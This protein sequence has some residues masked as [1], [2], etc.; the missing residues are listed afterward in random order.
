MTK[1]QLRKKE[2]EVESLRAGLRKKEQEL[3]LREQATDKQV[4]AI[5]KAEQQRRSELEQQGKELEHQR[6]LAS[7]YKVA[8]NETE[9]P[10]A[11]AAFT[12]DSGLASPDAVLRQTSL[13]SP[14]REAG[15]VHQ[16]TPIRGSGNGRPRSRAR[17]ATGDGAAGPGYSAALSQNLWPSTQGA[18]SIVADGI[19][20]TGEFGMLLS[21]DISD[22]PAMKSPDEDFIEN[23]FAS[24]RRLKPSAATPTAAS[25][26]VRSKTASPFGIASHRLQSSFQG[27]SLLRSCD[28]VVMAVPRQPDKC[29][30]AR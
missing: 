10:A 21:G 7:K 22:L 14:P 5:A 13:L 1:I 15:A 4:S 23:M 24:E 28:G 9:A 11:V 27:P 3:R 29:S 2:E 19:L 12:N 18:A 8:L 17:S 25:V 6:V 16:R 26:R 20:S 30:G